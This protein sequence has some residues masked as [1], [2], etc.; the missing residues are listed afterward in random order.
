MEEHQSKLTNFSF[1]LLASNFA[2]VF[3]DGVYRFGLNWF[4]VASYGNAEIL[5]I[6]TGFGFIVYVLNDIFVGSILDRFNRKK[7]LLIADLLG[8]IGALGLSFFIDPAKPQVWILFMLT[9]ILNVDVSYSYPATRAI[10]PD[11]IK[12]KSLAGFNAWASAA[13][14]T[15]QAMGP[16]VGGLLLHFEWINL[17][18][19]LQILGIMLLVTVLFNLAIKYR[20]APKEEPHIIEP[21]LQSLTAGFK[22]VQQSPKLF[23]SMLLTIW[24]NFFFEGFIL[25]MPYLIQHNYHGTAT[26]YSTALTLAAIAGVFVSV[27]LAKLPQYNTMS[28]M[29]RDFYLLGV[30]FLV[31]TFFKYLW[32]FIVLVILY[33]FA[34]SAFVIKI[35][36]VRQQASA[37]EYLGRVFGISFFAT[38]LFSPIITVA[39]GY[40]VSIMGEWTIF[41]LGALIIIGML[42][43]KVLS[44]YHA[45]KLVRKNDF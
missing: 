1:P 13:F 34:R 35:N 22:Y 23:E 9:F 33:G 42:V 11:V 44:N 4:L 10:L 3:G 37:P 41:L 26:S 31:A 6:L 15:G 19:F 8:A 29:Y 40:G 17:R 24:T 2:S 36:T 5:G 28:S 18:T 20:P 43:I 39:L 25:A 14:S 27:I 32:V 30:A 21:F 7:V 38:D 12:E 45:R 16:L